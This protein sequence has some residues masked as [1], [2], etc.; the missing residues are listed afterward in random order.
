MTV[1]KPCDGLMPLKSVHAMLK[2]H[3][4]YETF[5]TDSYQPVSKLSCDHELPGRDLDSIDRLMNLEFLLS[6]EA[7]KQ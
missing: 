3:G 5:L 1:V 7:L 6:I 4:T 2:D